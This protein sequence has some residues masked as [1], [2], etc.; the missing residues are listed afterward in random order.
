MK[1]EQLISYNSL[2]FAMWAENQNSVPQNKRTSNILTKKN[3]KILEN[4]ILNPKKTE[5]F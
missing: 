4:V 2:L 5:N 3:E 1:I